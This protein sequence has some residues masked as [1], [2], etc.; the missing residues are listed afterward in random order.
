MK[1]TRCQTNA[2]FPRLTPGFSLLTS[3]FS[4]LA[5]AAL[6]DTKG[7]ITAIATAGAVFGCLGSKSSLSVSPCEIEEADGRLIASTVVLIIDKIGRLNALRVATVF[8]GAGV[9]GQAL[10]NGNLSAFYASRFI[11]GLG[12]GATTV[13]S[14]MYLAEVAPQSIRGMIIMI[15][16]ACQQLGVVFGFW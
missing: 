9:L 16:A 1:L 8:Y 10:S 13:C 3:R 7:W 4:Q 2:Y 6:A 11:G 14:P 5:P 12:I 15:Y